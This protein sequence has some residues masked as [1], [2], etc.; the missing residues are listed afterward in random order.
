MNFIN[1]NKNVLLGVSLCV[2]TAFFSIQI[3]D[4]VGKNIFGLDKSPLSPI[5]IAIIIGI[6][7]SNLNNSFIS[8]LKPGYDFCIKRLLKLGIIFLGIRLSFID[9]VQYG[10]KALIIV[11]PSII[12][13]ITLVKALSNR[14]KI[15]KELS[16][17]IAV[18]TSICGATAI[19]ALAPS[20]NAKKTEITYAIANITVF[21]LFAMFF[22]PIISNLIFLNDSLSVGLFLGSSIHETAQVAG[23]AMIY[24]TQYQNQD[25]ID[26]ATVTKL[27]RNTLMVFVIPFLAQ[28]AISHKEKK[29]RIAEIFPFFV[30]GF[31]AFGFLR[32][33][34]D[35]FYGYLSY[36]IIFIKVTKFTAEFLLIMSMSAI[37]YNTALKNFKE[38]GLKP[39]TIGLISAL[40]VSISSIGIIIISNYY[41]I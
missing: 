26:I 11:L 23:S 24:S 36:W 33:I 12:I 16:L 2:L 34:G 31:L 35:Y 8:R 25:V 3:S 9:F 30:L 38:L 39:F 4:I 18:G 19:A 1:L 32:T 15:S 40:I 10:S 28:K 37:G 21:G 7:I 17:L 5:I 14:F 22:Y 27:L 29:N 20:I 41:I 6:S 13:T